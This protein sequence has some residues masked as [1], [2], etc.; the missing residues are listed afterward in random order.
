MH[1]L[2]GTPVAEAVFIIERLYPGN[3]TRTPFT[4]N[5]NL[6][7]TTL[8]RDYLKFATVRD[9]KF[10]REV[11]LANAFGAAILLLSLSIGRNA[12]AGRAE[13]QV[14]DVGADYSLGSKT[15]QRRFVVTSKSCESIR[16]MSSLIIIWD[17][18]RECL[19]KGWRKSENI[20]A[21]QR[22]G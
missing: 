15:I 5:E 7:R 9:T 6:K 22:L 1:A 10:H 19:A 8:N 21:P 16:T 17:L 4:P 2:A 20:S 14:C 3:R 13:E 18:P 12:I 11:S